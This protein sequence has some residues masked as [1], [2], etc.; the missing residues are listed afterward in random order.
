MSVFTR[1]KRTGGSLLS[2]IRL[3]DGVAGPQL[4]RR[5]LDHHPAELRL[6]PV[7][8]PDHDA[9][10]VSEY[11]RCHRGHWSPARPGDAGPLRPQVTDPGDRTSIAYGVRGVPETFFIARNGRIAAQH[12]GAVSYELLSSEITHLLGRNA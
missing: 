6:D 11:L 1:G 10:R 3:A 12:S 9:D 7:H 8:Q 5:P 2:E 4:G